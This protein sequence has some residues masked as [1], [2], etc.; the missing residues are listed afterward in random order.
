MTPILDIGEMVISTDK[1]DFLLSPSLSAMT[2]IGTPKQI[3]DAYTLLNGAE[4]QSLIN[5]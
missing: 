3:V 1:S 2:R 4:T 5:R